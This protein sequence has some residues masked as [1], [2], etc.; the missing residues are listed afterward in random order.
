VAAEKNNGT[1]PAT[2]QGSRVHL[3]IP[4]FVY[5]SQEQ[6]D[7]FQEVTDT[8]AVN[9]RG[10]LI[11]LVTPV[12]KGQKLLLV[13]LKTEESIQCSVMSVY[14]SKAG[15]P[16]V[17]FAFD[18]RSPRYWGLVFPPEDWD[19]VNRKRPEQ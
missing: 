17:G 3:A 19:P 11:G 10:G 12:K 8:V 13:N 4:V 5:G 18:Q 16:L 1:F 14:G 7:P 9:A 6:G 15:K 2:R